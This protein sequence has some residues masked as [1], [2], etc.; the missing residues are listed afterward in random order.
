MPEVVPA[1]A[2]YTDAPSTVP[3]LDIFNTLPT[4]VKVE[5]VPS[6]G[7]EEGQQGILTFRLYAEDT[8]AFVPRTLQ[9]IATAGAELLDL[10]LTHP[11]LEDVF[12]YLTGRK[13][14]S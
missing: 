12:I 5:E 4:V 11:S 3:L 9:A 14:R 7:G 8:V 13:L 2:V 6:T 1:G 10:H